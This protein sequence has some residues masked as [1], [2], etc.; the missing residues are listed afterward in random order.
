E[1]NG[2]KAQE[3]PR[4][5]ME[6]NTFRPHSSLGYKTPEEFL[7]ECEQEQL[8]KNAQKLSLQVV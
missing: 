3:R 1:G 6:Y 8:T 4:M 2:E 5:R 7:K